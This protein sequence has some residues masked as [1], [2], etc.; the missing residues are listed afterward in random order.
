MELRVRKSYSYERYFERKAFFQND[1]EDVVVVFNLFKQECRELY[2]L[3]SLSCPPLHNNSGIR[4]MVVDISFKE[5]L[6][7]HIPTK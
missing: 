1:A 4:K 7:L 5:L 6:T 2:V 3:L